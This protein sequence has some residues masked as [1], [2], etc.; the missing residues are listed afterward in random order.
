MSKS[1]KNNLYRSIKTQ[2]Y[3]KITPSG[4]CVFLCLL[5]VN[6]WSQRDCIL[7]FE[8]RQH[9]KN[10][11]NWRTLFATTVEINNF[12]LSGYWLNWRE[13]IG[14]WLWLRQNNRLGVFWRKG[15]SICLECVSATVPGS[16]TVTR[17]DDV[18]GSGGCKIV[19]RR[20]RKFVY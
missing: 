3:P 9:V 16:D 5:S 2:S 1:L 8:L 10:F 11:G 19:V 12:L 18:F 13:S 14:R 4:V 15:S 7:F 17:F 6:W 20:N